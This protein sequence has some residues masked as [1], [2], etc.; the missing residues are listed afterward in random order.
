MAIHIGRREFV[1]LPG[2]AAAW[3]LVAHAQQQAMPLIGFSAC[4]RWSKLYL[5]RLQGGTEDRLIAFR[6]AKRR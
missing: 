2:A 1:T 4:Q 5:L 6:V 3:P